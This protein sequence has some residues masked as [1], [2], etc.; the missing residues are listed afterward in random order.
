MAYLIPMVVYLLFMIGI[1][2]YF[3]KK[4]SS[5]EGFFLGDRSLGSWVVAFS[6]AFSGMSAWVLIG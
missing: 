2:F 3:S 5:L 4:Q 1:G 6:Y